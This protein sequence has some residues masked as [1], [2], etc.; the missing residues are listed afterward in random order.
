MNMKYYPDTSSSPDFSLLEKEIIKFWQENKIF[1]QSVEKRSKDHCFVFYDGPPFANGLPHYGH[2]LTGFIK[3]A[4]ARYQTM[5][6]KR[7]ERRFGWDCHGLPAEMGAEKELRIS[8]RTEIEKFGI[9]KF[10]NH[11]RT[12]VMKFSSEW[13]KYVNRQARWVDFHNDYKTMDKSFMESVMWAFKQ[14]YDKGLVYESIRVV[15]YS[16]ACETPLSNF[17]TR[18][19]NAYREKISKAVT[20]AFELLENPKQFKQKCKLLAWTTTPWTLPSNLALAIGKDIE[21]CAMLVNGEVCIFAESYLEKFVS[22]CEQS[23]I[24]Y[25][26]CNTKLKASDLAGLSYKPLFDYFKDTKNA[27]RV[28]SAD[29]VTAED[30]TGVVHTAPGFGEEDFYLCQSHDIRAV[31][32]IDN[33]GKFT[34]EVS[35]L[36][37]VHVFDANDTVI[38][39]LKEQG[40]WF[41]TEQ[42]IHNYPHCWRTDTPLI[43]RTM[44]SWYVAV[45]KFK[46]RMV[47]LNKRVNWMP[48][49]IRDGQF[50][51]WLEGAHD[52]SISRNRFWGT[53]IPVWKSDDAKYPRVDVYGSIAELERDFNVKIDDLH[54]PFIDTLIRPNPDDPTGKSVM[55]RVPD[56]FDCWFESGSMPFAQVHYPFE[57]K[58]WFEKNFP[59]DFITEY[60]AQT[61]GW[62]YTLF[63]LSTALFDSEPF[64]NCICHGVVLDVKGQKLSKRL[65]NYA[66]P[67]EVFDKYGSDALRF[68]MLSGSI[69]CGGNLL[70]DKEGKSIRDILKDVIK[71]IWNSYHFFT[72]YA[73]ADGIRAEVCK[74]Y[75]STIDRYMISKCFEAVESIQASMNNYNSQEAC[76]TLMNFFEVLNNWYIRRSRER[77]WKSDLDQDKTDAYNVLYTVFYYMLRAAAPLLPLITETIWQGLKYKETSVHLADFPQSDRYDSE[78]IAKMDLVREICNSALSI[79]NTFNMRIRQPLGSM[80]IYHRSSCDFLKNE[81]Q[82]I[83]RDEVNVKELEIVSELKEVASLELKLNFPLLGK[84]VAD[85]IKKLVQ[86]VKEEKWRQIEN[87]QIFLGDETESYTIEKGEYELLLKANSEYSSVFDNNKGIVVLTTELNDELILEGLARD[88]VRLIQETRKQAD[89]HISDRIGVTIKTEDEKIKKAI[90]TWNKYIK[91]QTLALSLDTNKEIEA[92]FYSK[93]Y[94]GLIVGIKLIKLQN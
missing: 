2:L 43:Y 17:E 50:G 24:Q 13:E 56:V 34:A 90:T 77:F 52:W 35:D 5:L 40:S 10:N 27:F 49:H 9:E 45:T 20:V 6:Q 23:N 44:P 94:Q 86:Y 54:R 87:E 26:N 74:D 91:E 39:K 28:F 48:N 72:M 79:R 19:D 36:T 75:Q 73:N 85:K 88:V 58:E 30:G 37:G 84:K 61:R 66:D 55:R 42:H 81:Y 12:S 3:D 47:E 14:L 80:T 46:S 21:Y 83:I 92:D 93:E 69:V 53:P 8:G 60:I 1:E 59:A 62:F 65:N 29:Y 7:V 33:G 18:L 38:K 67:M 41:K 22:H 78:L 68:L 15:P 51:K 32:P 25:E 63:V 64:K 76:K 4:F 57:N 89:F 82:E 31:C 71:P 16:W 70:L 11:C